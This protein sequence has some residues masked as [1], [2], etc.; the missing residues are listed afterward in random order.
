MFNE[1]EFYKLTDDEMQR[2]KPNIPRPFSELFYTTKKNYPRYYDRFREVFYNIKM[3]L[4]TYSSIKK[5]FLVEF[6]RINL[7]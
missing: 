6:L 4:F 2:L 1:T 3:L 7:C 5:K